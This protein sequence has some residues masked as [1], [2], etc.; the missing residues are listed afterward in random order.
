MLTRKMFNNYLNHFLGSLR[1]FGVAPTKLV[2][3]G[4][5]AKNQVHANSD[6]DLAIWA[7]SFEGF[8]LTDCGPLQ[9]ILS[10]F[11]LIQLRTYKTGQDENDDP[12]IA[13]IIQTGVELPLENVEVTFR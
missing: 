12:F 1:A 4:S 13:E 10:Q 9:P 5:Y 2:L 3:F 11:P 7:D 8:T 6:I